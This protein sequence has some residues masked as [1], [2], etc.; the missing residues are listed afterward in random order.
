MS[1]ETV[2]STLRHAR[3]AYG[4]QQRYAGTID[5]GLSE[6]GVQECAAAA[7][8]LESRV[9]DVVVTSPLRRAADTAR[10]LGLNGTPVRECDL[11]RERSFGVLEGLTFAEA[12]ALDPPVLFIAVGGDVH[13]V[14]PKGGEPFE[15]VWD[16]ARRFARHLFRAHEGSSVLVVS[17][18]VF[19]QM[20][21]GVLRGSNCVESLASYPGNLELTSFRFVDRVLVSEDTLKLSQSPMSF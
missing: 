5:V 10:L 20:L 2:I 16:R 7:S 1:A 18:G 14:N 13:S 4:E 9:F 11:C 17:H 3:T 21:H 8:A 12:R 15:V 19:L 6:R